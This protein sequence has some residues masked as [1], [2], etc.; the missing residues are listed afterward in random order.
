MYLSSSRK[1]LCLSSTLVIVNTIK[2]VRL[3][4]PFLI[5]MHRSTKSSALAA[6]LNIRQPRRLRSAQIHLGVPV[7]D[8]PSYRDVGTQTDLEPDSSHVL[9][10]I[11]I[12]F[13]I[14][15]SPHQN[16]F[17]SP[18]HFSS[19][20]FLFFTLCFVNQPHLYLVMIP[21]QDV[22]YHIFSHQYHQVQPRPAF[23]VDW[24]QF[25]SDS[26]PN[27]PW[28]ACGTRSYTLARSRI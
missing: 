16:L 21:S 10:F 19:F 2:S 23:V 6:I 15:W 8:T 25:R 26:L 5:C 28:R 17:F 22:R 20:L 9:L 18:Y 12:C 27:Q 1:N 4:L 13:H 3:H 14:T 7:K 24:N 11:S